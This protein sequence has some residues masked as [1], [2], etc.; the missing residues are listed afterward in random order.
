TQGG[1]RGDGGPELLP[2]TAPWATVCRPQRG[3]IRKKR[4]PAASQMSNLQIAARRAAPT[5]KAAF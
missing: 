3:S 5:F 1:R 2:L 4:P